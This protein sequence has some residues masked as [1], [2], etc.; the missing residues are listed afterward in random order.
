M[1]LVTGATG[2]VGSALVSR[3]RA[4]A[5]PVRIAVRQGGSADARGLHSVKVGALAAD[6]DWREALNGVDTVVHAAARVHVMNEQSAD[7][8]AE[9]RKT[10]VQGTLR[11]ARQ[12]AEQGVR[13]FVFVSSIKVNGEATMPGESFSADSKPAPVDPYGIS[14]LEAENG[15]RE[16]ATQ[17]GMHIVVVRPPL[18]Y[19]AGVKANF[20]ALMHAIERGMPLPL[21]RIQK[22]R[23]SMVAL[24]NLV[25]LLTTCTHHPNAVGQTFLVSD[26]EDLSTTQLLQRLARAM[27]K[28]ARLL[29][30][31]AECLVW[32]AGLLRRASVAQRLCGSLQVDISKTS[33]L[34]GWTPP[35]TVDEG[36]KRAANGYQRETSF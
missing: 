17:T 23:R 30:V 36:L 16:L 5:L 21:G 32:C 24:D 14:K 22:N 3:L 12:A 33:D 15:L 34:L 10:N 4:D 13:R 19:G 29:P 6:T 26:G 18:V 1:I 35:I 25:D 8:L 2:W 20:R 28:P 11:L 27:G 7:P 31:P 9:F